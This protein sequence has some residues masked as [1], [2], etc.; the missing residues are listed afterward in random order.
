MRKFYLDT[1][2]LIKKKKVLLS[3]LSKFDLV[4]FDL[5]D[6][7]FPLI[8]YDYLIFNKLCEKI[9]KI[10]GVKKKNIVNFLLY[11][12]HIKKTKKK[13]FKL[14]IFKFKLKYKFKEKLL[15][16]FYQ[17]FKIKE[18]FKPPSLINII[19]ELKK[20]QIELMI[21]TEGHKIRQYNKIKLLKIK[22]Y[23]N[24]LIVLDGKYNRKFKSSIKN[25]KKFKNIILNKNTIY[26]G[27]SNKDLKLANK[28]KVKF[29]K[30]D[31]SKYVK[32]II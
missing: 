9:F 24:H 7:I 4:I 6:T 10:H 11:E 12:K 17:N 31:I 32:F 25:L 20:K 16:D 22:N 3:Q 23:L 28:L 15:V 1:G 19:L 14:L 8:Y 30:F 29:Y 18:I 27:D 5:D 13:L 26:I 2:K 21:I